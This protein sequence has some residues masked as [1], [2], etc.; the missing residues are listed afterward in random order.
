MKPK[1]SSSELSVLVA[2]SLAFF[3]VPIMAISVMVALPAIGS[4]L[5]IDAV[6]LG[7]LVT[8]F[9]MASAVSV[10]PAGRIADIYGRKKIFL[11]GII[12]ST[13]GS[14]FL[15][16]SSSAPMLIFLRV[17]QG[18]GMAMTINTGVA[19]ISST[20]TTGKRGRALGITTAAVFSGQTLSYF[21][22]GVMTQHF[23]WRSV[24][25]MNVPLGLLVIIF[26]FGKIKGEWADARGE[27]V[28]V[29]GTIIYAAMLLMVI[30]GF[31]SLPATSGIWFIMGGILAAFVFIKWEKKVESPILNL[32]LFKK[33]RTVALS[34]LTSLINYSAIQATTFLLSLY[35]QYIKGL[36]PQTAGLVLIAQPFVLAVLSPLAGRL[37]DR[38][39]PRIVVSVGM[40]ITAL[41]LTQFIFFN[42]DTSIARI[43]AT[44]VIAGMG[45]S[46]FDTPNTNAIMSSVEKKSY[47]V[48]SGIVATMRQI[49]MILSMA[50]TMLLFS[51][52]IGRVEITPEY[53]P[54]FLKSMHVAFTVFTVLC[55]L[56]IV[57]SLLRGKIKDNPGK[58]PVH[59]AGH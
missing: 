41:V 17:L 29:V 24:F 18:F 28:D 8:A 4:D 51:F 2:V 43:L 39:Q 33:S 27:K 44:L 47:G 57:V 35:L 38:V 20:F 58:D 31:S 37:A 14:L 19:I 21:I 56:G 15:G 16:L 48:A 13:L 36:S 50:I 34:S 6:V 3:M 12:I 59:M 30:Y 5:G 42:Q 1:N 45:M 23:G 26:V 52:F 32:N 10:I 49:G 7:W 9:I 54:A 40:A 25:L 46:M 22:G 55:C 53:Y 11:L